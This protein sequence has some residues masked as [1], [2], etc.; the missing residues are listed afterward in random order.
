[1][2]SLSEL[3]INGL[4]VVLDVDMTSMCTLRHQATN[5]RHCNAEFEATIILRGSCTA[6]IDNT[7]HTLQAGQAVLIAPGRYHILTP[8]SSE[9]DRFTFRFSLPG[10]PPSKQLAAQL[11][12]HRIYSI[13]PEMEHLCHSIFGEF[14]AQS[15]YW[16]DVHFSLLKTLL[17]YTFRLLELGDP[18]NVRQSRFTPS[19][20]HQ[21][22]RYIESNLA[23]T[24]SEEDLA[25][26]LGLS[27]R[28]TARILQETYGIGFRE[29]LL[30]A[31][32]DR[33]AWLLRTTQK[34][35]SLI[36]SEV[37]YS[38]QSAFFNAFRSFFHTTPLKYRKNNP[39]L[40]RDS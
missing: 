3:N 39:F 40:S 28:Q 13:T 30:N 6:D 22:E 32:M 9:F 7:L 23:Q 16:E 8:T 19:R 31:R 38:S 34:P 35:L 5:R 20:T 27:R 21:I 11:G 12:S 37:G 25:Q 10:G 17:L 1:M 33:A 36:I 2:S 15:G 29:K 18:T 4:P 24:P 14:S 26:H